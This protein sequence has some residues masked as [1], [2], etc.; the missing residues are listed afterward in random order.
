[1]G[2]VIAS[3]R[4]VRAVRRRQRTRSCTAS[5]S[6]ATRSSSAVALA[7]LDVFEERGPL[8]NV[9]ANEGAFQAMLDSLRDIPIVGD[10]R[11]MG[12]FWAIELVKDQATKETFTDEECEWLLRDFLSAELFQPRPDLP[13]RRPRRPGDPALAAADRRPGAV[14]GDPRRPAARCSR[15]RR[16]RLRPRAEPADAARS[17]DLIRD[18]DVRLVAGE[19]GA[20]PARP[21][22]AHLRARRPDAVAV[23]RRAAAHHRACS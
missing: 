19:A 5:R 11:G 21:L 23:G 2:A 4:V 17:R 1:M 12:Y 3:D 13:R 16:G 7:N 20:R 9:R 10:V 18:L 22:G 15:R 8:G 14:R 6:A